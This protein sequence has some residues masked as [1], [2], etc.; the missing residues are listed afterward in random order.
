MEQVKLR[1]IDL[2][3]RFDTTQKYINKNHIKLTI[4]IARENEKL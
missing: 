3:S 2:F 1:D 4:L